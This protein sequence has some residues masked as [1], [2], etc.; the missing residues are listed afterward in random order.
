MRFTLPFALCINVCLITTACLWNPGA[1]QPPA[2]HLVVQA[3]EIERLSIASHDATTRAPWIVQ[4]RKVAKHWQIE[5]VSDAPDLSDRFV[6]EGLILHLLDTLSSLK[7]SEPGPKTPLGALGL[8]PPEYA[9]QWSGQKGSQSLWVGGQVPGRSEIN[10]SLDG[11]TSWLASGPLFSILSEIQNWQKLRSPSWVIQGPDDID[12]ITI[13]KG[14]KKLLYA[15]RD[16][17][18]WA[19]SLHRPIR[20]DIDRILEALMTQPWKKFLDQTEAVPQ[21]KS[22][23][24]S[25]PDYR[26]SLSG[27]ST[28]TFE[29]S[30]RERDGT[31]YGYNQDRPNCIF[32][33]EGGTLQTLKNSIK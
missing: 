14:Q 9:I 16:G 2:P 13:H 27:R 31:L 32:Q 4:L 29:L 15:Q 22:M 10:I 30:L 23:I 26:V 19:D 28:Q 33:L 20:Q 11:K 17:D 8:D 1:S 3:N 12:E 24:L 5:A 21:I 18:H 7:V 6:N 25:N